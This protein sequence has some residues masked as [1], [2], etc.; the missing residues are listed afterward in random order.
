MDSKTPA[1]LN[2]KPT[3][4]VEAFVYFF[5]NPNYKDS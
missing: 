1:T 5:M 3:V 4:R 2:R